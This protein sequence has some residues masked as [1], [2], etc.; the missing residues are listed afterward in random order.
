MLKINGM[1]EFYMI[2]AEKYFPDFFLG[3]RPPVFYAYASTGVFFPS[4]AQYS[5]PSLRL[6]IYRHIDQRP[7]RVNQ[8]LALPY[9]VV[10][11]ASRWLS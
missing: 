6:V 11:L 9:S 1:T 3:G 5:Q 2:I 4:E 7:Y 8:V 10:I